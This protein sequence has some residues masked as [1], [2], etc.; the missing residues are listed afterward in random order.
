VQNHT[1]YYYYII[2]TKTSPSYCLSLLF[3]SQAVFIVSA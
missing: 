1:K 2:V 3:T